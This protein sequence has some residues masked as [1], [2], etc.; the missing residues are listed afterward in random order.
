MRQALRQH[1]L[2]LIVRM[3][4]AG[5]PLIDVDFVQPNSLAAVHRRLADGGEFRERET[6][7]YGLIV[8]DVALRSFT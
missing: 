1:G 7:L 4:T 3:L 5:S 6:E 8:M 2:P